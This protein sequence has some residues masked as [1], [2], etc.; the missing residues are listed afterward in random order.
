MPRRSRDVRISEP[1]ITRRVYLIRYISF[2][3]PPEPR[4][5]SRKAVHP[6]IAVALERKGGEFERMVV[7][8]GPAAGT[9]MR[10]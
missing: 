10:E 9:R 7:V 4:R 3:G 2:D 6:E 8:A 1:A 5:S